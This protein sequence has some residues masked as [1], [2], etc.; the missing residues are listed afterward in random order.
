MLIF[1]QAHLRRGVREVFFEW[2]RGERPELVPRYER[3]YRR[4]AYAPLAERERLG[5]LVRRPGREPPEWRRGT[6]R[7]VTVPAATVG[8]GGQERLF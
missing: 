2:L 1:G 6:V 5:A 7:Q 3:L 4:G 8:E